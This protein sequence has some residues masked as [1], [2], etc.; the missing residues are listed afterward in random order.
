MTPDNIVAEILSVYPDYK[1]FY[2]G[3]KIGPGQKSWLTSYQN[4]T[5]QTKGSDV[6]EAN[7]RNGVGRPPRNKVDPTGND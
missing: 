4:M 5:T 7:K 2:V 3:P 1:P 6:R